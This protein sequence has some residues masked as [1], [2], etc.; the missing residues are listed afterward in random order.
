MKPTSLLFILMIML[1][2]NQEEQINQNKTLSTIKSETQLLYAQQ[3]YYS[4]AIAES[5]TLEQRQNEIIA[6]FESGNENEELWNEFES[7]TQ[8]IEKLYNLADLLIGVRPSIGPLGP[9]PMPPLGCLDTDT[10]IGFN[11]EPSQDFTNI[12]GIVLVNRYVEVQSVQIIGNENEIIGEGTEIFIDE[13]NQKVMLLEYRFKHT[14]MMHSIINVK[15]IGEITIK[16]PI[17]N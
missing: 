10:A 14:A 8:R 4:S 12:D 13:N 16:T 9:I 11:C 2:C 17:F 15:G 7:N 5:N 6:A 3:V 1:S